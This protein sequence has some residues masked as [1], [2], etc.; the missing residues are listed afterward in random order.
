VSHVGDANTC[1]FHAVPE[2]VPCIGFASAYRYIL[3]IDASVCAVQWRFSHGLPK[4]T[5]VICSLGD[6]D[7]SMKWS[8]SIRFGGCPTTPAQTSPTP[9]GRKRRFHWWSKSKTLL[10][11]DRHFAHIYHSLPSHDMT[12]SSVHFTT[13]V[14]LLPTVAIVYAQI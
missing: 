13:T 4:I 11:L 1:V 9:H 2:N 6:C 8:S 12:E 5:A 14:S 10:E 3:G 7:R